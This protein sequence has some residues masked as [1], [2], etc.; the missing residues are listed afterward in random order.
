MNNIDAW[1]YI[2]LD[3][4][5]DRKIRIEKEL[6][7]TK[8]F[9]RIPAVKH[10]NTKI[11]CAAS[12]LKAVEK[13]KIL[14]LDVVAIVEDD[15]LFENKNNL[16]KQLENIFS[17]DFDGAEL[18]IS[19]YGKPY[20]K[21]INEEKNIYKCFNTVG[22]V[23]YIL[24]KSVFDCA[25]VCFK[26]A[27]ESNIACDLSLRTLQKRSMWITTYPYV[28]KHEHGFSTIENIFRPKME[29]FSPICNL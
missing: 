21:L 22:K 3:E 1:F 10:D 8:K 18:W 27:I 25:I 20:V 15:F 9:I 5:T 19:P 23:G 17:V 13:A 2:N 16:E 4:S 14:N 7:D 29:G 24:K 12:H 11:G 28:G 26:N 6:I